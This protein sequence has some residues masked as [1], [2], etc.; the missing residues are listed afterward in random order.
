[1]LAFAKTNFRPVIRTAEKGY[2]PRFCWFLDGKSRIFGAH[3]LEDQSVA[4]SNTSWVGTHFPMR[5]RR[6]WDMQI[7]AFAICNLPCFASLSNAR[8]TA[9]FVKSDLH[10]TAEAESSPPI[11]KCI[12]KKLKTRTAPCYHCKNMRVHFSDIRAPCATF[13]L[14]TVNVDGFHCELSINDV[15]IWYKNLCWMWETGMDSCFTLS[16]YSQSINL[17]SELSDVSLKA[18]AS[19]GKYC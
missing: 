3:P 10:C 6:W 1:M 8:G 4:P 12:H 13:A 14:K 7:H 16:H 19:W 17:C 2:A 18:R 9:V 5:Y 11:C 15:H